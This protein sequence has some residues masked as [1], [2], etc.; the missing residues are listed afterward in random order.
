MRTAKWITR[1]FVFVVMVV[2]FVG[3]FLTY[4]THPS[5]F[6]MCGGLGLTYAVLFL[7]TLN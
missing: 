5:L 7:W 3:A 4:D 1:I 6:F 2:L